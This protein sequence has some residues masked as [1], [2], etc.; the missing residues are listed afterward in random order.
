MRR[1]SFSIIAT[2]AGAFVIAAFLAM[3]NGMFDVPGARFG[4]QAL[5]NVCGNGVCEAREKPGNALYCPMDCGDVCGDGMITG[6]ESCDDGNFVNDS[7]DCTNACIHNICGDGLLY[8]GVE[9]CDDGNLSDADS[10]SSS[11][12]KSVFAGGVDI[13][14]EPYCKPFDPAFNDVGADRVNVV[15]IGAGLSGT[16]DLVKAVGRASQDLLGVEPFA[17]SKEKIQFWY[18]PDIEPIKPGKDDWMT[19]CDRSCSSDISCPELDRQFRSI[20]CNRECR[21]RALFDGPPSVVSYPNLIEYNDRVFSHEFGHQFG[22]L[23]DEYSEKG[24]GSIP[25]KPNCAPSVDKAQEWWRSLVGTNDPVVGTVGYYPGCSYEGNVRPTMGR[26]SI[27]YDAGYFSVYGPVN[28]S[29]LRQKLSAYSGYSPRGTTLPGEDEKEEMDTTGFQ[30]KE[31]AYRM[32]FT[33]QED[34]TYA[35]TGARVIEVPYGVKPAM[36]SDMAVVV[37]IDGKEYTQTFSTGTTAFA[38]SFSGSVI[39]FGSVTQEP[40]KEIV[41]DIGLGDTPP[42]ITP[43]NVQ[44]AVRSCNDNDEDGS[45]DCPPPMYRGVVLQAASSSQSSSQVI[46]SSP[47]SSLSPSSVPGSSVSSILAASSESSVA[48]AA[49]SSEL[50]L[51]SASAVPLAASSADASVRSSSSEEA[52]HAAADDPTINLAFAALIVM[53]GVTV[54]GLFARHLRRGR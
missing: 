11:C 20:I 14:A 25:N 18:A 35:A 49:S 48:S 27:M 41:V 24:V 53:I 32:T 12:K 29:W 1:A 6:N 3:Q 31:T 52:V 33:R 2:Y 47:A 37:T 13:P 46:P 36:Q 44:T 42:S 39:R 51:S 26:G 15:F 21:S 9:E 17:S 16:G 43:E 5:P 50:A 34:G 22:R 7:D 4:A 8:V 23:A 54:G 40:R 45:N 28:E 10:C 38:E 30:W 19:T